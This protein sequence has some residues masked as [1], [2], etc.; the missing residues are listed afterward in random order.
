MA[1]KVKSV[2]D[3][4]KYWEEGARARAGRYGTETPAAA[5]DWQKE[6]V[7]AAATFKSAV[8]AVNIDKLF[9]GG[10]TRAG[11]AKFRRKVTDVGIGRFPS[12][13]AAAGPDYK[14]G[15]QPY[16]ETTAAIV[17]PPRKVRGDPANADRSLKV[18]VELHKKRLALR[19]A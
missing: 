6:T 18:Q 19:G 7:A 13:V 3:A 15:V 4:G 1:I 16:L 9:S 17:L 5:E 8:S 10:V 14:A 12:G 11:S 2:E